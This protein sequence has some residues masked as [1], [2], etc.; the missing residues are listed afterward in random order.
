MTKDIL[1]ILNSNALEFCM[2]A[3]NGLSAKIVQASGFKAIWASGLSISASLGVRD[4]NEISWTQLLDIV[5]FMI[6]A[7]EIPVL[8]DGDSGFGDFNNLRRV[9]K[10]AQQIGVAGI[11]IEDK[12]FPKRNSFVN[13]NNHDL[14]S[15]EVFSGKIKAAKDTVECSNFAVIARTEALIA[16]RPLSEAL[17]R[18][19]EYVSAG[20][21]AILVHSKKKDASEIMGFM[22]H[23][24]S[25]KPIIIVPT[26]YCSTK[27]QIFTDI[28]ISMVI[29]ANH[30][31][32][33]SMKAMER[34]SRNIYKNISTSQ[35]DST[36]STIEEVF[37]I[38][39]M[40]ELIE[41]EQK[42]CK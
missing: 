10:K 4:C 15:T 25:V 38:T 14:E 31:L 12:L 6:D 42:Y 11:C 20:A 35:V 34:V 8:M 24:N 26:T 7:V 1:K 17:E 2:E 40:Q 36:I 5:S 29:W 32:R 22:E 16:G 27:T 41:A 9:V 19:Y 18:A 39:N 21:D 30:N 23:W 37:D 28:G 3:H 33:A 13:G